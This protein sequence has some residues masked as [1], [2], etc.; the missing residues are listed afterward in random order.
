MLC[1]TEVEDQAF[2]LADYER[3][4]GNREWWM[5]S[6]GFKGRDRLAIIAAAGKVRKSGGA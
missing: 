4:G 2:N 6:K 5:Q 1:P 3:R